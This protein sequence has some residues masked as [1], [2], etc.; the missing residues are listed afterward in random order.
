M[1]NVFDR[2]VTTWEEFKR[3]WGGLHNFLL[4]GEITAG[5][6]YDMPPIER[7][8]EEVRRDAQGIVR[9]GVKADAFDLTDIKAEFCRL[10]VDQA[11][12]RRFVLAHF[13]LH[14]AL[15]AKGQVFEGLEERWV[16]PWRQTL[17]AQGFTFE[18]VFVILFASGPHSASNYHM[19]VTHQLAW[20]RHGTKHFQGLRD[21]DR[22]T[23]AEQRGRCELAGSVK[24]AAVAEADVYS[25]QQPSGTV[26]WN[27]VL[28][29]HWVETFDEPAATLTLV[30][31]GLRLN[32]E[33][34]PHARER[35][36]WLAS[37]KGS[38]TK[39]SATAGYR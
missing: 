27:A 11:L 36:A 33:L 5:F 18:N 22:W 28:T 20:Q 25:I 14:P 34:C 2:T 39:A 9:S 38:E 13:A 30:H 12:R 7:I 15:T 37:Q 4:G 10:P 29:P 21:P 24:P 8:V 35:E 19:D 26:L 17:I 1:A 23:T 32:G 6:D 31:T 3:H 16:E